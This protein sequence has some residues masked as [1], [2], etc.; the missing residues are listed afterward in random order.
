MVFGVVTQILR[1]TVKGKKKKR[2]LAIRIGRDR[3]PVSCAFT[4]ITPADKLRLLGLLY[5]HAPGKGQG[6]AGSLITCM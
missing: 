3:L 6:M 5:T 2:R 1:T 4:K